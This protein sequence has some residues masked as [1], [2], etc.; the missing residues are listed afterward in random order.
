MCVV[1][2]STEPLLEVAHIMPYKLNGTDTMLTVGEPWAWL[3]AFWGQENVMKWKAEIMEEEIFHTEKVSNLMTL[4]CHV[5]KYWGSASCAFRPIAVIEDK[6]T[7]EIALHWLPRLGDSVKRSSRVS[8]ERPFGEEARER[9]QAPAK[10]HA[11]YHVGKKSVMYSGDIIKV[12]TD[13]PINH[14]LPSFELLKMLW[15]LS[16]IVAMEGAAE[17]EE[18]DDPSDEDTVAV[19][20]GRNKSQSRDSTPS[21]AR[22]PSCQSHGS[23]RSISEFLGPCDLESSPS[24]DDVARGRLAFH[25]ALHV[26]R[27]NSPPRRPTTFGSRKTSLLSPTG[28]PRERPL[29][30]SPG[31]KSPSPAPTRS[32]SPT[33]S[34]GEPRSSNRQSSC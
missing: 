5:H 18:E 1:S 9:P 17:D 31:A 7:L 25:S 26:S 33:M 8:T 2:Q 19:L 16:R 29:S 21:H 6:R 10:G 30:R 15:H 12:T 28:S 20:A 3:T 4:A 32:R 27:E 11:I 14:P 13:D 23:S 22:S 24:F 34:L